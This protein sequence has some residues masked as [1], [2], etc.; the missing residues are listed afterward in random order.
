M[1]EHQGVDWSRVLQGGVLPDLGP[2]EAGAKRKAENALLLSGLRMR[3]EELRGVLGEMEGYL[4]LSS[5][6]GDQQVQPSS[7]GAGGVQ[8][9]QQR[10]GAS[11][12]RRGDQQVQP[13]STPSSTGAGSV[14]QH[15][16]RG[17]QMDIAAMTT[18]P[19]HH[20]L[21]TRQGKKALTSQATTNPSL[22]ASLPPTAFD[23]HLDPV[24]SSYS[25]AHTIPGQGLFLSPNA[26]FP[27]PGVNS[28]MAAPQDQG[29][30]GQDD[31]ITMAGTGMAPQGHLDSNQQSGSGHHHDA[32]P[33]R[34][35]GQIHYTPLRFAPVE[36]DFSTAGVGAT[37]GSHVS[38]APHLVAQRPYGGNYPMRTNES[39]H[40]QG[41]SAAT[42]SAA[43]SSSANPGIDRNMA[44]DSMARSYYHNYMKGIIEGVRSRA[45]KSAA[46]NSAAGPSS[47]SYI[48]ALKNPNVYFMLTGE[49]VPAN[50]EMMM[51]LGK[52]NT[53]P[54]L[55]KSVNQSR[56]FSGS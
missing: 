41:N 34:G 5:R 32:I 37:A 47:R 35:Q 29:Q 39:H 31:D 13:S 42:T 4:G 21:N 10:G 26:T 15:Q 28:N 7:T 54:R 33:A 56:C 18:T 51:N 16:Q 44:E 24:L 48:G 3:V 50:P 25:P 12:S 11:S 20:H 38:N 27:L 43:A 53:Y 19:A 9:H 30:M 52:Y 40:S 17:D 1:A 36:E 2:P 14:H 22:L 55:Q 45:A 23:Q 8:Q 49:R 46:K 6:G